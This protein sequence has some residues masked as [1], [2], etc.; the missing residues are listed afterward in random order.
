[1]RGN[2]VFKKDVQHAGE[3]GIESGAEC[4]IAVAKRLPSEAG[5]SRSPRRLYGV[6]VKVP[7]MLFKFE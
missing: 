7:T 4:P 1:M 2:L 6:V 3:G 5:D